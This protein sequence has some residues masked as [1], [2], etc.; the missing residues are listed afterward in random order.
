MPHTSYSKLY[1][2]TPITRTQY[3]AHYEHVKQAANRAQYITSFIAI[4]YI[5]VK[6]QRNFRI[7]SYGGDQ[8]SVSLMQKSGYVNTYVQ[9]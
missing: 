2:I 1:A 7:Q 8:W 3:T 4:G 5:V 9:Q 6:I